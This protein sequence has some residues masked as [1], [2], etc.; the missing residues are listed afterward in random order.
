[1]EEK[2]IKRT[3]KGKHAKTESSEKHGKYREKRKKHILKGII[4]FLLL[5]IIL[6]VIVAGIVS[7]YIYSKLSKMEYKENE[8]D[9]VEINEGID[10][11]GY[12]NIVLFGID[13][14]S[15][16]YEDGAGSDCILIASLNNETK[17]VR[18]VSVYRDSYLSADGKYYT[19]ITDYY[20]QNGAAQTVCLLNK[21]LDLDISEYININFAVVVDVV[22]AV[23]GIEMEITSADIK[24]I[25]QYIDEIINV[26]GVK[27]QRLTKPGT[28][29]LDGVQALAYARIRYIGTDIDRTNRQRIVL[30]KT[31]EKVKKMNLLK[32]NNLI[33]EVFPKVQTTFSPNEIIKL[34]VNITKYNIKDSIGFP[35]EWADYMPNGVYYLAPKN[36]EKNVINLHEE[37]FNEVDYQLSDEAKKISDNLIKKTGIK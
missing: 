14:R 26:T 1:M 3:K 19:K 8:L 6:F 15:N 36:L 24:Y 4:K 32:I 12:L 30:T 5:L 28:Y 17:D 11:T 29:T 16:D 23:G 2:N 37:L 25:N 13:A 20:R 27:S 31:F 34:A 35:Y 21:D 18:L 9:N 10:N 33:D 7:G 22:N